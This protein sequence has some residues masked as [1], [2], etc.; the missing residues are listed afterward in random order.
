MIVIYGIEDRLDPIKTRLS[1]VIQGCMK[2]VLDLPK[3]PSH[4]FIPLK[5]DDLPLEDGRVLP[6]I[7]IEINVMEGHAEEAIQNLIRSLFQEIERQ[8]G[9]VPAD[10][11]IIVKEQHD[12]S[13][14]LDPVVEDEAVEP[15]VELEG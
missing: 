9:I 5:V 10:V 3:E 1:E 6:G 7:V 8:L 12:Y 11:E 2:S 13:W 15:S 4:R 14:N